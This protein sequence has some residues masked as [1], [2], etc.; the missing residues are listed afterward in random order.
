MSGTLTIPTEPLTFRVGVLVRFTD[1]AG[2][3]WVRKI[4]RVEI[5]KP[6]GGEGDAVRWY[7]LDGLAV[8]VTAD[9]LEAA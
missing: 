7:L 4:R 2:V 9:D 5:L 8:M 6:Y 1:R 3:V